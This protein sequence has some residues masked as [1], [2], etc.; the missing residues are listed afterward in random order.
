[1]V[2]NKNE[3]GEFGHFRILESEGREITQKF[4]DFETK[5]VIVR[6]KYRDLNG[7]AGYS[8]E[9]TTINPK[10]GDIIEID[11]RK[12]FI[13][14]NEQIGEDVKSKIKWKTKRVHG[15]NGNERIEIKIF[16]PNEVEP[17]K[18]SYHSAFSKESHKPITELYKYLVKS[19]EENRIQKEK[20]LAEYLKKSYEDRVKY[21]SGNLHRQMRWNAESGFDEYTVFSKAW[22]DE[23]KK[24]EPLIERILDD[25]IKKYWKNYWDVRKIKEALKN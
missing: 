1:M 17:L 7:Y 9:Y 6:E 2:I 19:R 14:Y 12:N 4:I 20:A 8:Y 13:D 25:V 5:L 24:H 10:N 18:S 15:T 3:K 11:E 22:L 16:H 23:V 21:W